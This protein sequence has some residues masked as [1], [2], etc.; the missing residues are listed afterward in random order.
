MANDI[1]ERILNARGL[2]NTATRAAFLNP[3]YEKRH[4][5]F[6]LPDMDKAVSRL[7]RAHKKQEHIT[8]YGDYDIDG[9]TATTLLLDAL[10]SFGFSHVDAFIPNRFVEGYGMTVDAV[11]RIAAAGATLIITVDCGSLS[12]KEIVR[13]CELGVDVIVTDHHLPITQNVAEQTRKSAEDAQS[14]KSKVKNGKGAD[15]KLKTGNLKL[16]TIQIV[17]DAIAVINSKQDL[18]TYHDKMLCG[19]GVA[20]KLA[21]AILTRLREKHANFH[22]TAE[23]RRLDADHAEKYDGK[24][25]SF[26]TVLQTVS[27]LPLGWE[28]WMLDLV[29]ISTI[30]DMV[31]LRKENRALAHFGLKVLRKTK[32]P[33][34]LHIFNEQR[35]RPHYPDPVRGC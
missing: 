19:C 23:G 30:A 12:E 8:I 27:K 16:E 5:P 35:M 18:C 24:Q 4:D 14:Q 29:G 28:K 21:C 31:P 3:A 13:A 2:D 15:L 10:E 33:G 25:G 17:P 26:E 34:L 22:A 20:W 6:L 9:L 7:V 11:E 1:F 32:R